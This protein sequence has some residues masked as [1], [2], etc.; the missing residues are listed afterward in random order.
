MSEWTRP[1]QRIRCAVE[2]DKPLAVRRER[3]TLVQGDKKAN[4]IEAEVFQTAGKPYD[5]TGCTVT[6]TFVRPDHLAVPP[7]TAEVNGNVAAVTLTDTCYRVSG[8]YNA[9]MQIAK[10][11]ADRTILWLV[12]DV[13]ETENDGMVDTEAV[14]PTP[15][16][17]LVIFQQVEQAKQAANTAAAGAS[18]AAEGANSATSRADAAATAANKW[19]NATAKATAI[20]AESQP[21]VGVSESSGNKVI[22]FGIPAGKTPNITFRVS[23]GAPGTQVQIKQSGTPEAPVIDLTIPRGDTGAVDGIDY[24]TGNPSALGTES[25]GT[26]NGVAR[27]DHVHPLPSAQAIGALPTNGTAYNA[28]RFGG[29][30]PSEYASEDQFQQL[31]AS[32]NQTIDAAYAMTKELVKTSQAPNLLVNSYFTNPVNQRGLTQL[33]GL[34]GTAHTYGLIDRWLCYGSG[35]VFTVENG[36]IKAV[37]NGNATCGIVQR[38]ESSIIRAGKKYTLACKA[39]VGASARLSYGAGLNVHTHQIDLNAANEIHTLTFTASESTDGAHI[40]RLCTL[41]YAQTF[42]V[43]WMALYEG[44]YTADTLP[45]YVPKGYT[46]ELAECQRYFVRIGGNAAYTHIGLAHAQNDTQLI[47]SAPLPQPM[48]NVVTPSVIKGGET[49]MTAKSGT[50]F[51]DITSVMVNQT[52]VGVIALT[53]TSAA[54]T[55]GD[56]FDVYVPTGSWLDI[57]ADL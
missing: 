39:S 24:F 5:M 27:G 6:L 29:M 4:V 10:D 30:L 12:G 26:A 13:L 51:K 7:I 9:L 11:G 49:K 2:M 23:T 38:V 33:T 3:W 37:N 52:G 20:S 48:R 31:V 1:A 34:Q 47:C 46:E 14:F 16:E 50:T 36:Y 19:A 40:V 54:L 43:E 42:K 56:V 53:L 45:P 57:S 44:E 41:A 35:T 21:T 18:A 15:E 8:R 25:P 32:L 17:M 55:K 22:N 28:E